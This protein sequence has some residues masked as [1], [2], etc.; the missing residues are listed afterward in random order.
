MPNFS[1]QKLNKIYTSTNNTEG[2]NFYTSLR[3]HWLLPFRTTLKR[4]RSPNSSFT[5]M[6]NNLLVQKPITEMIV[7]L[8]I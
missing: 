3:K 4:V 8:T 5:F 1:S 2:I 7:E 6:N